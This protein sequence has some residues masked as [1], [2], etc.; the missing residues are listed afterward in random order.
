MNG[1]HQAFDL[2]K[3]GLF[4]QTY[5]LGSSIFQGPDPSVPS[6]ANIFQDGTDDQYSIEVSLKNTALV[7]P[8]DLKWLSKSPTCCMLFGL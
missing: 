7:R 8:D 1:T 2:G 6:T 5:S 4:G 3:A